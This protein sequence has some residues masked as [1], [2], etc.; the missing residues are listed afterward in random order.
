[1]L[2]SLKEGVYTKQML[3]ETNSCL[4]EEEKHLLLAFDLRQI[5]SN[6]LQVTFLRLKMKELN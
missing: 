3:K 2:Q 6:K 4:K 1:V 5:K